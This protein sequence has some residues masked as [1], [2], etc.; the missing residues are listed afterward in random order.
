MRTPFTTPFREKGLKINI[1][2]AT[3]QVAQYKY[4]TYFL[5][6]H[7]GVLPKTC[8]TPS[9]IRYSKE[10]IEELEGPGKVILMSSAEDKLSQ[11]PCFTYYL[12]QALQGYGDKN[13][14]GFCSAE[15][16]F[17]YASN[18]TSE[19]LLKYKEWEQQPQIFDNYPG[20]LQIL[21]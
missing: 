5:S 21:M 2:S 4:H 3:A 18:L 17:E 6:K 20:E 12:I 9:P 15:E 7:Q 14:D 13:L 11:G 1:F 19:W 8:D 10:F 16:A